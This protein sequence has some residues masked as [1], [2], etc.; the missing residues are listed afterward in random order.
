MPLYPFLLILS[1]LIMAIEKW[2]W[3]SAWL[4]GLWVILFIV[5]CLMMA[6]QGLRINRDAFRNPTAP[7]FVLDEAEEAGN[8]TPTPPKRRLK[9][10]K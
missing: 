1:M 5:G 9:L 4:F 2:L 10:V 7:L 3:P 8:T 6:F